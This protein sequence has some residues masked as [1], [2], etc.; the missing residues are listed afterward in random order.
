MMTKRVPRREDEVFNEYK[1]LKNFIL[2][3][4]N[5][6]S[7][8]YIYYDRDGCSIISSNSLHTF[9]A[10]EGKEAYGSRPRAASLK[11]AEAQDAAQ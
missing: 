7:H 2:F 5:L 9:V 10:L 3:Y 11:Q 8:L 6:P 4:T 1:R